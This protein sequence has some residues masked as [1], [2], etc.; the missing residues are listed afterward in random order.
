MEVDMITHR[1][2]TAWGPVCEVQAL[3]RSTRQLHELPPH[4]LAVLAYLLSK[5]LG[6]SRVLTQERPQ[7]SLQ[8][9][10]TTLSPHVD[11]VKE[12][13]R[14]ESVKMVAHPQVD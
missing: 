12:I 5:Y 14:K 9:F 7:R 1:P 2:T 3:A 13:E 8:P 4:G 11:G 6:L 10:K